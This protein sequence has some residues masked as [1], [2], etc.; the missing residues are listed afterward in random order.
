[1]M[2]NMILSSNG[3]VEVVGSSVNNGFINLKCDNRYREYI[4]SPE[5]YKH[6]YK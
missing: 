6:R 3:G 2:A 4:N 1:M 5:G